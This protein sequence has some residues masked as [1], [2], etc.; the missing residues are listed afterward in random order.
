MPDDLAVG[1]A[2]G[3]E[4]AALTGVGKAGPERVVVGGQ[5]QGHG[6]CLTALALPVA[7]LSAPSEV[8][9][10]DGKD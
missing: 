5:G 3:V 6:G 4:G 8:C 7:A 10:E 2:P 9:A 1:C